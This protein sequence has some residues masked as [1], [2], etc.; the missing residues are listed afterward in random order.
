MLSLNEISFISTYY[1]IFAFFG[2]HGHSCGHEYF[3]MGLIVVQK[4][5]K[6]ENKISCAMAF[7]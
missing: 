1:F 6:R 7:T 5:W 4:S 2:L 3:K